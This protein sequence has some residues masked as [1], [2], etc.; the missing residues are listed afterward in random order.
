VVNTILNKDNYEKIYFLPPK[1]KAGE[2]AKQVQHWEQM[3]VA[4]NGNSVD[5]FDKAISTKKP[6][7]H[8]DGESRREVLKSALQWVMTYK[9]STSETP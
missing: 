8:I 5:I 2:K 6:V 4:L 3:R 1:E 9:P 7:Y